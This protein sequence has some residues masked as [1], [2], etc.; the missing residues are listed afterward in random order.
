VQQ[1]S[2]P[3]PQFVSP[4]PPA[5]QLV[6]GRHAPA[7]HCS[8]VVHVAITHWP[9]ELH[10]SPVMPEVHFAAPGVQTGVGGHEQAPHAQPAVHVCVP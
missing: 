8:A 1:L 5:A 7:T 2:L 4:T 3:E 10:V 9:H 6:M